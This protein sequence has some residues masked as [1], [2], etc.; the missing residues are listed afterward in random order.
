MVF[1]DGLPTDLGVQTQ[2]RKLSSDL[3][4]IN[5]SK[6]ESIRYLSGSQEVSAV[7]EERIIPIFRKKAIKFWDQEARFWGL[8]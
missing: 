4:D 1:T 6:L 8:P 7:L 2:S 5:G 3:E